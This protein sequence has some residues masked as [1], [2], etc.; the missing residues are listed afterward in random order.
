MTTIRKDVSKVRKLL[1]RF[2]SVITALMVVFGAVPSVASASLS[3]CGGQSS[4]PMQAISKWKAMG[5]WGDGVRLIRQAGYS[6]VDYPN[7][8]NVV[9]TRVVVAPLAQPTVVRNTACGAHRMV[10]FGQ[11]VRPKGYPMGVF[12]PKSL[13]K[14]DLCAHSG[15]GCR[16]TRIKVRALVQM[17]CGN[18]TPSE[19]VV[20]L[21]IKIHAP[22]PKHK[23]PAHKPPVVTPP[24]PQGN[25]NV[26]IIGNGN[27]VSACNVTIVII[28]SGVN[29]VIGGPD[30]NSV[31]QAVQQYEQSHNC[32]VKAPPPPPV[33]PPPATATVKL[34]KYAYIDSSKV[35]TPSGFGFTANGVAFTNTGENTTV[36]TYQVG[37]SV[38]T[39]E[40]NAMGWT[41]D[42]T[43]E[44]QIVAS[45]GNTFVFTNSKKTPP[46]PPKAPTVSAQA[47]ACVNQGESNGVVNGTVTNPNGTADI[48]DISLDGHSTSVSVAANG[49]ASFSLSGF[50]PGTYSG[51]ATLR[52]AGTSASFSVPVAQCPPSPKVEK[53]SATASASCPSS[54]GNGSGSVIVS[55]GSDANANT[56]ITVNIN[57]SITTHTLAPGES[58]TL[59]FT[60]GTDTDVHIIVT[61]SNGNVLYE[62]TFPHCVKP[63]APKPSASAS[64]SCPVGGGAG[65]ISVVLSNSGNA[66][67]VFVV[68]VNGSA[69]TITV[70]AGQTQTK[71]IALGT[72][73]DVRV[74][75]ASGG[76][77]LL[78]ETFP[79]CAAPPP[80]PPHHTQITCTGF[81]EISGGGSFLVDC[82]VS[83]DNGAPISLSAH[84]NDSNTRVS[85]INCIS[86]GGTPS[87]PGNGTYEFRVT[88]N[89]SGSTIL[90]S[91]ITAVASANG[92]PAT[93]T[94]D[95][96]PVDPSGGGF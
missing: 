90:Y 22:P 43:C 78:D 70:P 37:T 14:Q 66:D 27:N 87:C 40:V 53:P 79:K 20:I 85:G 89:N 38:T 33:V 17:L 31:N 65:T 24:P 47:Q 5:V 51:T 61:S 21:I 59:N 95:P 41:Q 15:A 34:V 72:D 96:F 82:D 94:S 6:S 19:V 3:S 32:N 81:E 52:T 58:Q 56:T 50:A 92:V 7:A 86:N 45:N 63:P 60:V 36:G 88:G 76:V 69:S 4:T 54:G 91:S 23:P 67:A 71:T 80:P 26:V 30:S 1:L 73:T 13:T 28:C 39:C 2:S 42:K 77:L 48:A 44:T 64:S 93:F 49:L 8:T 46:P 9:A 12:L 11:R 62:N 18:G 29:V 68:D 55:N 16:V 84:S 75:V 25:C 74:R 57:G 10:S 83:S 35:A